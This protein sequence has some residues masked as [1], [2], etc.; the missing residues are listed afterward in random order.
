MGFAHDALNLDIDAACRLLGVILVIGV[1]S[2]KEYLMLRLTKHLRAQL[3]AHAQTRNHL[4]RHLGRAFQVVARARRDV[5]AHELLGNATAQEHGELVEHL[6]L[7]LE[8]V[9]LLRKLQCVAQ[10]LTAADDRD[11]MNRIGM[12]QDVAHQGVT[13]L[14][15]SNRGALGFGHHAALALRSGNHTLHRLLDL[16]HR[17]HRTMTTS[18]QQRRL[19][20]QVRQIGTS[21]ANGHLGE[22]LKLNVLVHRL[23]LSMHAQDLLAA[24]YVRTVDRDLTVKTA[25]TQ[26][27]RIQNIGAVGGSDQDDRLALL[28]TVHLDQQLVK[29]LLALVVAAAQTGSALTSYGVDL[30]DKDDRWGLG[31][32]LLKEVTHAAG[33]DAHEHL[34]KVR[35]RDAKERHARLAGNGLG[36][37]RLTGTRRAHQQHAAGNLGAQLAIAVRVAQEIANLFELLDRLIHAGNV[38]ELDLGTRSLVGLGISLAKLHVPVVGAH[39]LAHK[40][41]HDGDKGDRRKHTHRQV[42]PKIGIVGVDDVLGIGVLRHKL[43]KRIGADIGRGEA[44]ELARIALVL[45]RLPVMT[46]HASVLNRIGQIFDAILLDGADHL[47]RRE[48]NGIAGAGKAGAH[49]KEGIAQKRASQ[50]KIQPARTRGLLA[51]GHPRDLWV[52]GSQGIVVVTVV[53]HLTNKPP[54]S[55][56][57]DTEGC[58][59]ARHSRGR[60]PPQRHRGN[61]FQHTWA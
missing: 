46:R 30:V 2:T 36:Q 58:D 57:P 44:L 61:G 5:I 42:A 37:Q 27:R 20:E 34:N 10:G 48:L 35:A 11:L 1:I 52:P 32:G 56:C 45:L 8:E 28:K 55:K 6:V 7:G 31:L 15:V 26:Q 40:V 39:H 50:N 17:D 60:S 47:A 9:I 41:E 23:V 16:V 13:A 49:I 19:V 24:L 3:L 29:R 53:G 25:G 12:L 33:A 14:V 51:S 22:L 43:G 4:A 18:G 21:K 38:L 59:S 54:V